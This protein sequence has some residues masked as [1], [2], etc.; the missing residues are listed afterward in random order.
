MSSKSHL[1]KKSPLFVCFM[2][3]LMLQACVVI[4]RPIPAERPAPASRPAS[5]PKLSACHTDTQSWELQ[6]KALG[7]LQA[8]QHA[9]QLSGICVA[10]F[11]VI[12][13]LGSLIVSGSVYLIGNTLHWLEFQG[14]CDEGIVQRGL[15]LF[16]ADNMDI[17]PSQSNDDEAELIERTFVIEENTVEYI[18]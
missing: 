2:S 8:C 13:P 7:S 10:T 5:S 11:G 9:S 17:E 4:P 18:Q 15:A 14:R 1:R 16:N 12:V 6:T 3:F